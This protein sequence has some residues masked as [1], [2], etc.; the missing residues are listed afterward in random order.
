LHAEPGCRLRGLQGVVLEEAAGVEA[1]GQPAAGETGF[2]RTTFAP[3]Q[4][5]VPGEEVGAGLGQMGVIVIIIIIVIFSIIIVVVTF[6]RFLICVTNTLM[7]SSSSSWYK[8]LTR[9]CVG[10][11]QGLVEEAAVPSFDLGPAEWARE[12]T[13][14]AYKY[15]LKK[16]RDYASGKTKR[17]LGE[18]KVQTRLLLITIAIRI[19]HHA[20]SVVSAQNPG[21]EQCPDPFSIFLQV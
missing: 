14:A 13:K 5:F 18:Q 12:G 1:R 11:R 16:Q 4:T 3:V 2:M 7:S 20:S 21:L 10:P 6:V 9:R 17:R 15:M 19:A 8:R